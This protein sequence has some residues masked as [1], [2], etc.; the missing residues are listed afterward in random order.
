MSR[1]LFPRVGLAGGGGGLRIPLDGALGRRLEGV[2]ADEVAAD[3]WA[4][5]GGF[6]YGMLRMDDSSGV[7]DGTEEALGGGT[8]RRAG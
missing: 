4:L 5:E 8:E 3:V 2:G 6:R 1:S 7:G